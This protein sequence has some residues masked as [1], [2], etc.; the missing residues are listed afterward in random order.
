MHCPDCGYEVDD[1][2]VFC[3]QCRFQFRETDDTSGN[4]DTPFQDTPGHDVEIDESIFEQIPNALSGKELVQMEVQLTAP[5]LLVVLIISLFMFTV[6]ATIPFTPLTVGGLKFGVTGIVCLLCGLM[7][8]MVFF[9]ICRRSLL[10][11]RYQ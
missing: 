8:G 6:I 4:D 1:T 5:T 10:R 7:A 11:F 3:P 9:I 2:A